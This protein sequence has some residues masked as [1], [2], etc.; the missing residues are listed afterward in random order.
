MGNNIYIFEFLVA[1][2]KC[3]LEGIWLILSVF[4]LTEGIT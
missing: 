2:R 3:D 4:L 1:N